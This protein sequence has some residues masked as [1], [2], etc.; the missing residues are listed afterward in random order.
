MRRPTTV[1]WML[2][3]TIGLWALNLTVSRYILTHGFQPL[4]YGSVRYGLAALVFASLT[5]AVERS[6]RISRR[7]LPLV[8]AAAAVLYVNQ[9][10]FVYALRSTT[11]SVLALILGATPIFAA[12]AG[13]ALRTERLSSRFWAGALLSFS[14]VALVALGSGGELSGDLGGVFLGI[15]TAATWAAYSMLV[16]PLMRTY[17]ASRI[18][19]VVL[20]LAWVPITITGAAQLE[21]Q[22]WALGWE[23]WGLLVFATI[24]PLVLTNILW[25]RSLDRIGP[26]RATLAANLQPFLAAAIAV[27]LLSETLGLL[28]LAGGV[29]IAVGILAARRRGAAAAPGE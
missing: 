29:L 9:I 13:L 27:V 11:A 15:L 25:F 1:E 3:T 7:H 6:L 4:A 18:S 19:S 12:C 20:S 14:G 24:G 22:D 26:S 2:L 28:E 5:L 10:A 16:T 21:S 23:I 17:S 8:F